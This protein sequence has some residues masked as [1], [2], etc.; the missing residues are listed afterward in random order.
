MF[1][2]GTTAPHAIK[3]IATYQCEL[4]YILSGGD[5]IRTCVGDGSSPNGRWDGSAPSCSGTS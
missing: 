1:S 5:V 2:S 3:T 4:G